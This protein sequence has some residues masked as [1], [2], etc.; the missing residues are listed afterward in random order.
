LSTF[1]QA[2][3]DAETDYWGH[4]FKLTTWFCGTNLP[5]FEQ[6]RLDA[7]TDVVVGVNKFVLDHDDH[8]VKARAPLKS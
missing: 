1:E 7:G 5:T 3:L 2:R 8:K 4:A 6:A